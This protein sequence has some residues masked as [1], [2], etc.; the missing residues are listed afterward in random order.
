LAKLSERIFVSLLFNGELNNDRHSILLPVEEK[1]RLGIFDRICFFISK[2]SQK[3]LTLL[4][5]YLS[6]V[7]QH[8]LLYSATFGFSPHHEII[9]FF[10]C[11]V[12][13]H[14][15]SYQNAFFVA[16]FLLHIFTLNLIILG[17]W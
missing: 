5:Q 7:E 12:E 16:F 15:P 10:Q 4:V 14:S 1:E 6:K 2:L 8:P 13:L 3:H 9:I 17:N 11:G